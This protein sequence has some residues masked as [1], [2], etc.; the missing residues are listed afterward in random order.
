M[1]RWTERI[2]STAS[3]CILVGCVA[4]LSGRADGDD[5]SAVLSGA[6]LTELSLAGVRAQKVAG[7]VTNTITSYSA[8]HMPL[9][10]FGLGAMALVGFM[11]RT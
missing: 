1:N 8:E 10:L 2:I 11:T 9:V 3:T 5:M 7:L 4:V 6:S